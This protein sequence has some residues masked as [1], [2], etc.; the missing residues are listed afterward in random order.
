MLPETVHYTLRMHYPDVCSQSGDPAV[1][2]SADCYIVLYPEMII[3][4]FLD[5]HIRAEAIHG[6]ADQ[7]IIKFYRNRL[8]LAP[9][10]PECI[11]KI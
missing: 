3:T 4:Y 6:Y 11:F 9:E 5:H 1:K 8:Y 7:F 10:H 2:L